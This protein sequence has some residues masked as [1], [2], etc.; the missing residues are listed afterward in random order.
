MTMGFLNGYAVH[1]VRI[2]TDSLQAA[3][4]AIKTATG[5]DVTGSYDPVTDKITLTSASNSPI[6]LGAAN[7]TSNFLTSMRLSNNGTGT[8]SSASS[9]GAT[10]ASATL[11]SAGL[12][13]PI[14]NV[15]ASGNGSFT[16]NGVPIFPKIN[17]KNTVENT[18]I[19]NANP[20]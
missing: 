12:R 16:V 6:S 10:N 14:T 17:T 9:L 13:S 3:F 1:R 8:T 7:D 11:A 4:D 18:G 2:A 20:R 5:D 19:D 15:D